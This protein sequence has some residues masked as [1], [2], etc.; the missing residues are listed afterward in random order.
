MPN[1]TKL[2]R[3]SGLVVQLDGFDYYRGSGESKDEEN[4]EG[5]TTR[6]PSYRHGEGRDPTPLE[7]VRNLNPIAEGEPGY[8]DAAD[9]DFQTTRPERGIWV[10]CR[11]GGG[12]WRPQGRGRREVE[13]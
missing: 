7:M 12:R 9:D 11:R 13:S 1:V 5:H 6:M 2:V 3:G 10:R 4:R 8:Y